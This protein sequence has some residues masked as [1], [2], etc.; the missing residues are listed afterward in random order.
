MNISYLKSENNK[1]FY[2]LPDDIILNVIEF[3]NSD[4]TKYDLLSI[5]KKYNKL[6]KEIQLTCFYNIF[7]YNYAI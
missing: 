2:I 5:S 4:K 3:I 7:F 6:K 1:N